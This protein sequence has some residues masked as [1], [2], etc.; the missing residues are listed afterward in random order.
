MG[1]LLTPNNR[2]GLRYS[3]FSNASIKRPNPGLDA[4]QVSYTYQ[5]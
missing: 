5:F 1:F 2:I 4:V 3:H